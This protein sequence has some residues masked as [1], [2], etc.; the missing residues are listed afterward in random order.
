M[1]EFVAYEVVREVR[2]HK[3]IHE[4]DA[5]TSDD[6]LAKAKAGNAPESCHCGEL[7]EPQEVHSGW[8]VRPKTSDRCDDAA[9]DDAYK[10]CDE[11]EDP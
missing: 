2:F 7:G 10:N 6:A 3:W 4:V 1:P 11:S 5:E 8:A 9:W